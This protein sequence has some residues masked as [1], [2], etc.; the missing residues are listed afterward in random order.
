MTFIHTRLIFIILS[1]KPRICTIRKKYRANVRERTGYA[2]VHT[3]RTLTVD[4]GLNLNEG[5]VNAVR[6]V[7]YTRDRLDQ[8]STCFDLLWICC[9]ACCAANC[10]ANTQQ[11]C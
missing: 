1:Q 6:A 11:I 10:T 2:I 9:T 8:G 5:V 3:N 7:D 4:C